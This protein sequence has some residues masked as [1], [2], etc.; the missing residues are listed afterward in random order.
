MR[1][2]KGIRNS[3]FEIRKLEKNAHAKPANILLTQRAPRTRRM[4]R[5]YAECRNVEIGIMNTEKYSRMR[6][7]LHW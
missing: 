7:G 4:F 2:V 5:H 3:K 6:C 1:E